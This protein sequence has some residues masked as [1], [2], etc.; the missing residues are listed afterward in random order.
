MTEKKKR[1]LRSFSV[2]KEDCQ[3][4]VLLGKKAK[5]LA[6]AFKYVCTSNC[7]NSRI[8]IYGNQRT[9]SSMTLPPDL[10]C[11]SQVDVWAQYQCCYL[12]HCLQEIISPIPFQDY[13]WF[14]DCESDFIGPVWFKGDQFPSSLATKSGSRKREKVNGYKG[15][16]KGEKKSCQKILNTK[17]MQSVVTKKEQL[18]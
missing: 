10:D 6:L 2:L 5:K 14:F 7:Q 16:M 13:G 8:D 18:Q 11:A 15:D 9:R 3:A 12:V 17:I 4:F 1:T